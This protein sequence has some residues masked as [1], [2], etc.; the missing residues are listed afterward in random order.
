MSV[1]LEQWRDQL[2][3]VL[4]DLQEQ[5]SFSKGQVVVIGCSTSE[6]MGKKIGTAGTVEVAQML[7]EELESFRSETGTRL[8]FQCCEHLNRALIVE[9]QTALD[10]H[11]EIVSVVPAQ[12]AGGAM[13]THAFYQMKDAVVVEFIKADAGIDIGDTLIGMHLKHVAV[14][15]RSSVKS[16]GH[17]HVTMAKTRP[18]LIGGER[19]VYK[20]ERENKSCS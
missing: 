20:D 13:A 3:T 11:L 17:A 4:A 6:V 9:K 12:T 8:A 18:K 16:I 2:K 19:A 14:P 1:D 7:F 5:A 15:I 10:L